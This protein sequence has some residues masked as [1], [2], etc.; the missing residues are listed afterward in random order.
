MKWQTLI[1]L[2]P[3][4]L[5]LFLIP[6]LKAQELQ[7]KKSPIVAVD[8]V[9][10]SRDSTVADSSEKESIIKV[11]FKGKPGRA[12]MWSAIPGGGQ[13]YNNCY[14]KLPFVYAGLGASAYIILRR[15]ENY[16]IYDKAFRMRVD[17]GDKSQDR[18]M[19]IYDINT[20][21][22]YRRDADKA[23]FESYVWFG[24][25]YIA[26]AIEAYVDRHLMEFDIS[27]DLSMGLHPASYPIASAQVHIVPFT[28]GLAY[29][30]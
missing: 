2:I 27:E 12:L 9:P 26:S 6:E 28:A 20:L 11:L 8:S 15:R 25:V 14:W 30:F 10:V 23:L 17:L 4:L 24:L 19:G 21:Q 22:A 16:N 29:S 5:Y 13:I 18:F 1:T 7:T 3:C